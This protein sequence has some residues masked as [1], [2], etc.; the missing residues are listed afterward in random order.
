MTITVGKG[1]IGSKDVEEVGIK[2]GFMWL[3]GT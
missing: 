3:L 1:N 2:C